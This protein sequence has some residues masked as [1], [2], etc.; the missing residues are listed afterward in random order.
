[1]NTITGRGPAV[2]G[3]LARL[4][5]RWAGRV[6]APASGQA[7]QSWMLPGSIG[8]IIPASDADGIGRAVM[9]MFDL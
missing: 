2:T 6:A 1:M 4:A 3:A 5:A 9:I 7:H 8:R